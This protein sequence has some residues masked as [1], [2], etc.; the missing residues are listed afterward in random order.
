MAH[1]ANQ[2]FVP[3]FYLKYFSV[4]KNNKSLNIFNKHLEKY[5]PNASLASQAYKKY[6]Y[7]KDGLLEKSLA[8]V[9]GKAAVLLQTISKTKNLPNQL[10]SIHKYLLFFILL[11]DLRNLNYNLSLKE[12]LQSMHDSMFNEG[13]IVDPKYD[14]RTDNTVDLSLSALPMLIDLCADLDFKL[15]INNTNK[16]FI[17]SDNPV[18]RYNQYLEKLV[19][20]SMNT[21][22][23]SLGLQ[24]LFPISPNLMT[25]FYDQDIYKV[26]S[27]KK[28]EIEINKVSEIEMLNMLQIMNC[29]QNVYFNNNFLKSDAFKL[30]YRSKSFPIPHQQKTTKI[31]DSPTSAY[32]ITTTTSLETNMQLDCIKLTEI[33]KTIRIDK[34]RL[35]HMRP[36]A[37]KIRNSRMRIN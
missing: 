13:E 23:S 11:T 33:A 17:T 34:S 7:G 9:E 19:P 10:S 24:I 27:A 36:W 6:Y 1:N 22:Y 30:Y 8:E 26:G 2:H 28:R 29:G 5:I 14:L 31:P 12:S 15:I 32:H 18:I 16:P 21:G 25:V 35:V 37:E 3:K 4:E 20:G